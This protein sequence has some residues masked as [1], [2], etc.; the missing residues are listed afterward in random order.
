M[1][2]RSTSIVVPFV[3]GL[4][5]SACH[6]ALHMGKGTGR[7]AGPDG[8]NVREAP[9]IETDSLGRT[10]PVSPRHTSDQHDEGLELPISPTPGA[11]HSEDGMP[12]WRRPSDS[13]PSR[14]RH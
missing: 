6:A 2:T 3:F 4:V 9:K 5:A 12:R 13:V 7:D 8:S 1:K 11:L 14:F 10:A